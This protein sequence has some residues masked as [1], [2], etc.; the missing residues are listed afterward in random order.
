MK[1]PSGPGLRAEHLSLK[2]G[3][4]TILTDM[5]FSIEPGSIHCFIGPNGGGKTSTLRCLLGQMPHK[6]E[7]SIDWAKEDTRHI[8]GYVPQLIEMERSLPLTI[9]D[10]LAI[11][12]QDK[13]AFSGLKKIHRVNVD[14]VLEKVG[15][16]DK[17]KFMIGS[18]SGGERQRLLFAQA[19]LPTP[20][21]L[22][23]DEPMTSMDEGGVQT[24]ETLV[25]D[26]HE[27][28]ITILWVNH[29]LVQVKAM[30]QT[31]TVIDRGLIAHGPTDTTLSADMLKGIFRKAAVAAE[32]L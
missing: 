27:Q 14:A 25:K 20:S 1:N 5:S 13:P 17:R 30:S 18:L 9:N 31:I 6:G 32:V 21:L 3:N 19:L 15:L 4:S 7:I 29:D 16:A 22:V 10:F 28:G 24:F 8:I 23:L 11:V 2:L 12:S 26:L